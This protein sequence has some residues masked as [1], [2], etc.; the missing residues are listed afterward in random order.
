MKKTAS[1]EALD[2]SAVTPRP[3]KKVCMHAMGSARM[4]HRVW[5][6]AV[7][8]IEAGFDV[9]IVDVEPD[10]TRRAEETISG[11]H[12]K[13]VIMPS[14]FMATRFKPLFLVKLVLVISRCLL[15][16]L[17]TS[18]DI[19]H[20]NVERSFLACFIAARLRRKPFI[21]DNPELTF[22]YPSIMRWRRLRAFSLWLVRCIAR[23]S[24]GYMTG[25]PLYAQEFQRIYAVP[26]V[27]VVRH[28]PPYR[29]ISQS[30]RLR[31]YL[32]LGHE[33]R[34]ALYQGNIQSDR[35]L[36]RLVRAVPFL[37]PNIVVV[38][39]GRGVHETPAQLEALIA[40]LDI[41]EHVKMIPPVPQTELLE[42]TASA[43]IGLTVL[44]PDHSLSIQWCLPNKLFEYLMAGL[45]VLSTS[46]D[47]IVGVIKTY[48]VGSVV[49]SLEPEHIGRAIN[50]MLADSIALNRMHQN[51]LQVAKDE[52]RWD[53]ESQKLIQLYNKILFG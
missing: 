30:N 3:A 9:T 32:G 40:N 35:G 29:A 28:V 24:S 7:T 18:A 23:Y 45:P 15:K 6:N 44:P 25:S 43:D 49:P 47:A 11:V 52:L 41:A 16:L 34:I 26:D 13:H 38:M 20:A 42:W 2:M 33:V 17:G 12:L 31:E 37:E 1:I 14:W 39:M 5:R 10:K 21:L 51:A 22:T 27:T 19:Y 50:T 48:D 46:L 36:D 8:L 4:D 53:K